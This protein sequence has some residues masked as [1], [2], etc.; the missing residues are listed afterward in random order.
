MFARVPVGAHAWGSK[1]RI[2]DLEA[3]GLWSVFSLEGF[4]IM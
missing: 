4:N 3:V 1:Y 2:E